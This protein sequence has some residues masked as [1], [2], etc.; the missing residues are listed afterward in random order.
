MTDHVILRGR[1]T[2]VVVQLFG[3]AEYDSAAVVTAAVNGAAASAHPMDEED[4]EHLRQQQQYLQQQRPAAGRASGV[5]VSPGSKRPRLLQA[6]LSIPLWQ[7]EEMLHEDEAGGEVRG[8]AAAV[9]GVGKDGKGLGKDGAPLPAP[10]LI[11]PGAC[12]TW[13]EH[14]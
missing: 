1:Y 6:P 3:R 12:G 5:H 9:E 11:P 10:Q 2:A 7:R 14:I 13:V 4:V 8:W